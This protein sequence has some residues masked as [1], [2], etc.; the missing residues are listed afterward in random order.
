M[1]EPCDAAVLGDMGPCFSSGHFAHGFDVDD[2]VVLDRH[3]CDNPS[4]VV[5]D[6][7][8]G[9]L[10]ADLAAVDPVD[11]IELLPLVVGIG[12]ACWWC[13]EGVWAVDAVAG[14]GVVTR[15]RSIDQVDGGREAELEEHAVWESS[16]A[17]DAS[18]SSSSSLSY[19][20]LASES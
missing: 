8:L 19:K 6:W 17:S 2:V 20:S 3:K 1:L 12:L 13:A 7:E 11:A 14:K 10:D 9:A 18:D 16:D 15:R 4:G 5:L